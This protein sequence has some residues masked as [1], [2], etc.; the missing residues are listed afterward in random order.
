MARV[1]LIVLGCNVLGY[2]IV[3]SIVDM[4]QARRRAQAE[5]ALARFAEI[6]D[7]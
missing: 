5:A 7:R 1:A 2:L 6:R 3:G 4:F